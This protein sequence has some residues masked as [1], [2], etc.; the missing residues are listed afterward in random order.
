MNYF[1]YII[2]QNQTQILNS[3]LVSNESKNILKLLNWHVHYVTSLP[4]HQ[5]NCVGGTWGWVRNTSSSP[6][7]NTAAYMND[8]GYIWAVSGI[9]LRIIFFNRQDVKM[10][11]LDIK[12]KDVWCKYLM[13]G[14][15]FSFRVSYRCLTLSDLISLISFLALTLMNISIDNNTKSVIYYHVMKCFT[16]CLN[17]CAF[18]HQKLLEKP[19]FLNS[20]AWV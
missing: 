6:S 7:L 18:L 8:Q 13:F 20:V 10:P 9:T 1:N 3:K 4:L 2:N 14:K 15:L 16:L 19:G 11:V 17:F 5:L 12:C